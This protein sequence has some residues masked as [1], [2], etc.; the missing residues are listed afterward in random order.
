MIN[1]RK[2]RETV[3]KA[4]YAYRLSKDSTQ[5][6]VSNLIQKEDFVK[7]KDLARFAERLFFR[8]VE[9]EEELDEIIVKHIRNWDIER[10]ALIDRFILRMALCEFLYFEEIPTKVSLNEAIELAKRYSTAKSGRFIN[11][12]LDAALTDLNEQDLIKKT[13]RGLIEKSLGS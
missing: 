7:E 13:G 5:H 12:I 1:R 11:G 8:T 3:L 10:L 9:H 6:I 2:V 4:L